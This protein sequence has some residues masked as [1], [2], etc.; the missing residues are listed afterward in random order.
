[1]FGFATREGVGSSRVSCRQGNDEKAE[2]G[3]AELHCLPPKRGIGGRGRCES[4]RIV[5]ERPK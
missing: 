1:M 2:K 5:V 3:G 4:L